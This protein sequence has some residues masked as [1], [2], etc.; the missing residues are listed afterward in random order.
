LSL[1]VGGSSASFPTTAKLAAHFLYLQNLFDLG[2]IVP[3][4]WTLCYEVQ[5]YVFII[6]LLVGGRMLRLQIATRQIYWAS[7]FALGILFVVS[8][9]A[10][11]DLFNFRIH[12]GVAINRWF[13]FF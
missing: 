12:Q 5:F 2:D 9:F 6:T 13:Q 7:V 4:F 3:I 8:V 1:H 11:Y 10:R